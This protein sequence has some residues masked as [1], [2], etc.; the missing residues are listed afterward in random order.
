[1]QALSCTKNLKVVQKCENRMF[2]GIFWRYNSVRYLFAKL[3]KLSCTMIIN[4]I[5]RNNYKYNHNH[6]D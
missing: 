3:M 1:L 4:I 5:T 6:N 2:I